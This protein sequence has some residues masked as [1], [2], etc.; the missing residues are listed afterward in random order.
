[1]RE[2]ET[3]SANATAIIEANQRKDMRAAL[4]AGLP[5]VVIGAAFMSLCLPATHGH[6]ASTLRS[7]RPA[8]A[9][10]AH[11]LIPESPAPGRS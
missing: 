4:V 2:Y 6:A 1:M 9:T 3:L 11:S 8:L 7:R 10:L 5:L